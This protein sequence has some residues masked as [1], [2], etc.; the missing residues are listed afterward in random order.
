MKK[1]SI[2]LL[3]LSTI[4]IISACSSTEETTKQDTTGT[5]SVY[6]F[7][8]IPKDTVITEEE[9]E[10]AVFTPGIEEKYYIVQIGAFTTED[11][12]NSFAEMS[13]KELNQEVIVIYSNQV[14]L[15]VV[16]LTTL[17]PLRDGAEK[18]RNEL[19]EMG[20]YKDAW[21]LTVTK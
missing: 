18:V 7:D 9:E 4:F 19:W 21:I 8:E 12:A 1:L 3:A 5:D 17:F 16:Q 14:N 11:K 13:R 6:V 15:F 2:Y 10:P 20:N